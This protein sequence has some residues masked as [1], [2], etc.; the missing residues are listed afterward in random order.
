MIFFVLHVMLVILRSPLITDLLENHIDVSS[1]GKKLRFKT[2]LLTALVF[3]L[4][5]TLSLWGWAGYLPGF[6]SPYYLTAAGQGNPIPD[7]LVAY[8]IAHGITWILILPIFFGSFF[9]NFMIMFILNE[10]CF[11]AL[12]T[13]FNEMNEEIAYSGLEAVA[14]SDTAIQ[15]S[16]HDLYRFQVKY[17]KS[18]EIY[19]KLQHQVALP[20]M[21][22]WLI[23]GSL[24]IW[25]VWSMSQGIAADPD[26]ERVWRL[27]NYWNLIVRLSWF[28]GGSP[29]F[30]AGSWI[31]GI[32]PWLSNYYAW[33]MNNLTKRLLFKQPSMRH[34]MRTFLQEFPL[35]F[36]SGFLQAI[37]QLLPIFATVLAVNT[38]GFV[39]DALRIFNA[40]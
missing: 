1:E 22:F 8:G 32:L 16:V 6:F 33:K 24:M 21:I 7:A 5:V 28:V 2:K 34:S 12:L 37:P 3:L 18:W 29:W 9:A 17:A 19:K 20:L 31:T 26:D 39:F 13:A 38:V 40:I 10:L 35:E 14:N 23:E 27:K 4:T 30:G 25:S 15:V 11:M 36:R